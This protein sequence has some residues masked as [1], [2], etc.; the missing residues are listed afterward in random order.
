M[1]M[2]L[3]LYKVRKNGWLFTPKFKGGLGGCIIN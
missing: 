2:Y 3:L 1:C